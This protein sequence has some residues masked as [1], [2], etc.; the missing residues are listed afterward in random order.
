MAVFKLF[1]KLFRRDSKNQ[2]CESCSIDASAVT[3][4]DLEIMKSVTK[5]W[6][7]IKENEIRK[8]EK[9]F[10]FPDFK[11]AMVFSNKV[12]M[13]ADEYNHH[14]EIRLQWG[15]CQVLWWSHGISDLTLRDLDLAA[16]CNKL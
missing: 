1:K 16:A 15:S 9:T 2:E 6:N 13:L 4:E 14:P 10:L 11:S 12:G 3:K 5:G 8:I 7:I